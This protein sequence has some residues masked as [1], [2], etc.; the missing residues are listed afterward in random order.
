MNFYNIS[1]KFNDSTHN[2]IDLLTEYRIPSEKSINQVHRLYKNMIEVSKTTKLV[3][4]PLPVYYFTLIVKAETGIFNEFIL[5]FSIFANNIELAKTVT[6]RFIDN[7]KS[8][9]AI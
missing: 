1:L 6:K 3:S 9:D 5:D 7:I 8:E 4:H 2:P